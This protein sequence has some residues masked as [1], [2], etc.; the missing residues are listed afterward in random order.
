MMVSLLPFLA[1]SIMQLN[2]GLTFWTIVTFIVVLVVLR[3][4]AWKPIVSMLDEREKTIRDAI[5]GAK[6]ERLEAEKLLAEQKDAI[7]NARR[8]AAELIRKNQADV[9]LAREAALVKAK[10]EADLLLQNARKA[11]TEERAKAVAEIRSTAVE[12]AIAAA[13]KLLETNLDEAK[14]RKLAEDFLQ[15]LPAQRA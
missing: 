10:E 5:E 15:K 1:A 6:R 3:L 12:L 9:E 14:Q 8:E 11:I 13:G 7:A 4:T 2:P